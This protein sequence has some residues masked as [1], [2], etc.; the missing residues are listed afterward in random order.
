MIKACDSA[1]ALVRLARPWHYVK[2]LL[3]F[4]PLFF[5]GQFFSAPEKALCA[6]MAWGSMSL[7]ASTVYVINDLNDCERDRQ[8]ETKKN[9]PI[10]SGS[11]S[12]RVAAGCCFPVRFLRWRTGCV[13]CWWCSCRACCF[14]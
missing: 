10:A 8:H 13:R 14:I 2:N 7:L 5:S 3:V 11:I 9:R 6:T 1:A 4:V 12:K